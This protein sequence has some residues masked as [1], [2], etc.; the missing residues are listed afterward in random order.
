MT[1]EYCVTPGHIPEKLYGDPKYLGNGSEKASR[2]ST[3]NCVNQFVVV[4]VF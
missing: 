1:L 2:N 3:E 4:K